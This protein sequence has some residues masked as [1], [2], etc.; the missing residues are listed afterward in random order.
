MTD[1]E[2]VQLVL[3]NAHDLAEVVH[4][5][6]RHAFTPERRRARRRR[7][8]QARRDRRYKETL[9]QAHRHRYQW[10]GPELELA[11]RK[12]LSAMQVAQMTGRT[13]KAVKAMRS[14][15]R[16]EPRLQNLRG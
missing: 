11:D 3:H 6:E 2:L 15:L 12:D 7:E 4:Q 14:K 10:T 13:I 8:D 5:L 1:D 9:E 16:V